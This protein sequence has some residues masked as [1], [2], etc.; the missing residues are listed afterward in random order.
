[1][2]RTPYATDA[3]VQKERLRADRFAR[4]V[5]ERQRHPIP[6]L[7]LSHFQPSAMSARRLCCFVGVNRMEPVT[8]MGATNACC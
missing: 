7:S 4:R 2:P 1:M 8:H 6:I 5:G 3:R